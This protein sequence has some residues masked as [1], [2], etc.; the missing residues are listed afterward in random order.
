VNRP[1]ATR[2]TAAVETSGPGLFDPL[3]LGDVRIRNRLMQAAH[4]RIYGRDGHDSDRDIA[5]FVRRAKGG[6]G[7]VVAGNRFVHPSA[8]INGFPDGWRFDTIDSGRRLTDAVHA[9]GAAILVQLNHQGAQV[10]PDGPDG[11]R[12]VYSASRITSPSTGVATTAATPADLAAFARGWADSAEVAVASGFDGIEVHLAHGY[13]LNQFLSPLTNH[14]TDAYGGDVEG[15]TRFPRE[16]LRAV[17]DRVGDDVV[18]GIR[19]VVDEFV[20]GGLTGTDVLDII[21]LLRAEVALDFIDLGAGGYHNPHYVFPTAAMPAAWMRDEV[22]AVKARNPDL[23]VFGPGTAADVEDA[24]EVIRSG[25]ADMVA[26]TR[27]QIAD[28][29]LATKL[30]EGRADEV[31]HCIKLNQG[32]LGRGA[33][34]LP[35]ACT[36]NPVVGREATRSVAGVASE[37]GRWVVVGGGPAGMRAAADLAAAGH[38]VT[39]FEAQPHLGGQLRLAATIPGRQTLT[40]LIAD[41]TRDVERAGVDVRVGIA[42]SDEALAAIGPDGVVI[43]TGARRPGGVG[44]AEGAGARTSGDSGSGDGRGEG[45]GATS[46]DGGGALV[47][48]DGS[49]PLLDAWDA[50][51]EPADVGERVAVIDDDGT[52][53]A[54]GLLLALSAR[55][56][57]VHVFTPFERIVPL[58]ESTMDRG[59]FIERFYAA[60]GV[61]TTDVEVT[62]RDGALLANH[63][64]SRAA[65]WVAGFDT[66]VRSTPRERVVP[67]LDVTALARVETIGDALSPRGIDAA[68]FEAFELAFAMGRVATADTDR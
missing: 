66:V 48:D 12:A 23:V 52:S 20:A 26:L 19:I 30:R 62:I 16:V 18:V 47:G 32:C 36:V 38:H 13:L 8:R 51:L 31:T 25:V 7:L 54:S 50:L 67:T 3:Q 6:V 56:H 46:L 9:H 63:V 41:L 22:A 35:V 27:A 64:H 21:D 57:L 10:S 60:G 5:Y 11:P 24:D 39:L 61:L 55:G 58:V 49:L 2:S 17:R 65:S 53:Q 59:L 4:S 44:A 45:A 14:R 37:A 15:R 28:P 34:G 43:A 68:I 1:D 42:A 29:D 33:S 40:Q